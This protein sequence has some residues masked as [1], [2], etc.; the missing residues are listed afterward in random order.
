VGR[1][2]GSG[3]GWKKKGKMVGKKRVKKL[4]NL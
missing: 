4:R 3:S 1:R 2:M